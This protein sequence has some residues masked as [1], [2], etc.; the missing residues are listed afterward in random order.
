MGTYVNPGNTAFSRI[1]GSDY[2][3]KTGLI[4]LIN[5]RIGSDSSLICISRPRRFG[6]TYAA[7]MLAA[8]YDCSCDSHDLFDG[9]SVSKSPLYRD[10]LNQ[11]N[12]ICFD[13][14]TFISDIKTVNGSL[15]DVPALIQE[16]IRKDLKALGFQE[17]RGDSLS[18]YLLRCVD[19]SNGRPF[20]FI[21]DEWDALFREAKE[22]T[23]AQEAYLNLLRGWFKSVSFTPKAVA[24]AY[25]TG[26]LP[27]KKDG[28]QSAISDFKEYSMIEPGAYAEYFGFT[29]EE[30]RTIC[31]ENQ[32]PFE[33]ARY[34]YDG[35]TVGESRSMYN[36]YSVR[37][38]VENHRFK[39][40]WKKTSAAEALMTYIDM[41]Q[42]GL[43]Q[44]IA[45]LISGQRIEVDTES[46]QN[47]FETFSCKDDVLTLLIHLGYL[48]YTEEDGSGTAWIPNE[49]VRIEFQK[50][51]RR[52]K[53][54][55]LIDLV[56]KSD[57]L[58]R[59]TLE[60]R[61][62]AVSRAIQAVHD[63]S[64]APTFYN[65]EQ[66]LRYTVKMA[67]ISCVDQFARVEELPSGH[68][69]A[70]LVYIPK[71]RSTLPT[72]VI[73]LKWG[74]GASGA[75]SQ[76]RD[77]NYQNIPLQI[78]ADILLVGIDYDEKTKQHSCRIEKIQ[79]R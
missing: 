38:A 78:G 65:E 53:H 58:L 66:A 39:S 54:Q 27:I 10:Y 18:E 28:S 30:V 62:D 34:W 55:Q 56:R 47:D 21:I 79:N 24:A 50:I 61:A 41:D 11:F 37:E 69:I 13:V 48:T 49:E 22:D 9:A 60:G 3:D 64:F 20:I 63:T 25:I 52:A 12:I 8:Y 70:D 46:F 4:G 40:Y 36:P 72:M 45:S 51:L 73:E 7:K 68:G 43:Q 23:I 1:A 35:Y 32:L 77:R 19:Q 57:Q 17:E 14:T 26:I 29:E 2:V 33:E 59:D 67:Y 75:I 44:D 15:R 5:Q 6:K 71:K 31:S 16:A 74:K 76:I 42:D